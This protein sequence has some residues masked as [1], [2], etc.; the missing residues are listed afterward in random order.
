MIKKPRFF[1]QFK[2]GTRSYTEIDARKNYIKDLN[3]FLRKILSLNNNIF[4]TIIFCRNS[5]KIKEE[6]P[7]I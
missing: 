7:H 6:C 1:D 4:Y 2:N 5:L 3:F